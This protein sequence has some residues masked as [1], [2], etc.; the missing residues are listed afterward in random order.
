[1]ANTQEDCDLGKREADGAENQ[2]TTKWVL[3]LDSAHLAG[4]IESVGTLMI[5]GPP[6][7][8]LIVSVSLRQDHKL[9]SSSTSSL[10][11]P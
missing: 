8:G 4:F 10:N 11:S 3:A 2:P 6:R 9:S 1:M 7:S 5:P